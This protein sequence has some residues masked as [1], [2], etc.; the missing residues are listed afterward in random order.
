MENQIQPGAAAAPEPLASEPATSEPAAPPAKRPRGRPRKQPGDPKG[1]YTQRPIG[2]S[3]LAKEPLAPEEM[4][5]EPEGQRD[6][7]GRFAP[8]HKPLSSGLTRVQARTKRMLEDLTP[9]A[10]QRLGELIK[11]PD[12][13]VALGASK[14]VIERVTPAP[15]R[16]NVAVAVNVNGPAGHMTALRAMAEKRAALEGPP[17]AAPDVTVS[18]VTDDEVAHISTGPEHDEREIID[19]EAV[20]VE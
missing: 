16:A 6:A 2:P 14:F 4:S 9:Y 1:P 20:E 12:E 13:Q 17:P 5:N 8:G 18:V 11:S 15:P 19:V 10:V 3:K 7:L